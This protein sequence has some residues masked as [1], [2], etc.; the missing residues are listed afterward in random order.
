MRFLAD[1]EELDTLDREQEGETALILA[2][3]VLLNRY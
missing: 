2:A 3:N 1:I